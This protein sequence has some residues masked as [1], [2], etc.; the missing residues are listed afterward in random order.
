MPVRDPARGRNRF[1]LDS[2]EAG[3][4]I[5]VAGDWSA[6]RSQPE[7]QINDD[8][9]EQ[10]LCPLEPIADTDLATW[11]DGHGQPMADREQLEGDDALYDE[12]GMGEPGC[13]ASTLSYD[14]LD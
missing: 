10:H 13:V 1:P 5:G 3:E 4:E 8:S 2:V 6:I 7:L 11:R 9:T 14:L 12:D